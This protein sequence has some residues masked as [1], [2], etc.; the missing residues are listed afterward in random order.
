MLDLATV[1]DSAAQALS[2]VFRKLFNSTQI[3]TK[4]SAVKM[5]TSALYTK[6]TVNIS[7]DAWET[8]ALVQLTRL[9]CCAPLAFQYD[10]S[11]LLALVFAAPAGQSSI[12]AIIPQIMKQCGAV[13][14]LR[15]TLGGAGIVQPPL[16]WNMKFYAGYA[17]EAPEVSE[18][19]V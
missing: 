13:L 9:L 2:C 6:S 19:R 11:E 3:S 17:L 16:D 7:L 15:Y 14:C 1:D 10:V 8:E 12:Q 5:W 4:H 18:L